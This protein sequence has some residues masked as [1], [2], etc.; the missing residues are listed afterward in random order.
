M[1]TMTKPKAKSAAGVKKAPPATGLMGELTIYNN[2]KRMADRRLALGEML[3]TLPAI[4]EGWEAGK[5]KVSFE[6][7]CVIPKK[8]AP[9]KKPA[10]MH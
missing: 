8:T 5:Y 10:P 3:K 6:F 2:G 7:H 1:A 4:I 9:A